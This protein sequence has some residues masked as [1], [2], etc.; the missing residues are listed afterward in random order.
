MKYL[1]R[2]TFTWEDIVLGIIAFSFVAV[3]CV[4]VGYALIVW[5]N[6]FDWMSKLFI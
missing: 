6:F 2:N 1:R 4:F 5:L 3:I